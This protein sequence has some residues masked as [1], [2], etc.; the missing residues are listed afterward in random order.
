MV[1]QTAHQLVDRIFV[2]IP[3][4]FETLHLHLSFRQLFIKL[5]KFFLL[6]ALLFVDTFSEQFVL[7][8]LAQRLNHQIIK[9]LGLLHKNFLHIKEVP[10]FADC[11]Q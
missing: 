2:V 6:L 9:T 10:V 1:L 8:D 4:F 7:S 3:I 5:A 11:E